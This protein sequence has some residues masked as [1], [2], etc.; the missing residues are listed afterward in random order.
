MWF[1]D[2]AIGIDVRA[3]VILLGTSGCIGSAQI[4]EIE[5][6]I[7]I[8]MVVVRLHLSCRCGHCHAEKIMITSNN[9]VT[10]LLNFIFVPSLLIF[11]IV[12][13]LQRPLL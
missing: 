13:L 11:S 8:I 2:E 7:G 4:A 1:S 10:I 3:R 6:E 5:R 12:E 9:I